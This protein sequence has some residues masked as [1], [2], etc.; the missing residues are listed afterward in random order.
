MKKVEER[1]SPAI[2]K[3]NDIHTEKTVRKYIYNI[4]EDLNCITS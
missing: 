1:Y 4:A 3:G 2:K